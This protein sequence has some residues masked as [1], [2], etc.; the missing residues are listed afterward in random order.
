MPSKEK[1]N[2]KA[3]EANE[4]LSRL[5]SIGQIATGIAHEVK[6]PLTAV[7]G[8]LQLLQNETEHKYLQIAMS[9]LD[10]ALDTLNNLLQVSRPD[11]HN[12]P[13]V[14]INLCSELESIIYLFQEHMYRVEFVKKFKDTQQMIRGRK[15]LLKKAF[16]NLI[17]NAL[18]AIPGEGKITIEHY[19][20]RPHLCIKLSDT[21][22]GIPEE[23]LKLLGTP[24]F[25]TKENGTGMGLTQVY[26]TLYDHGATVE[27]SSSVNVGTTF[28]I[29]F[30]LIKTKEV[31]VKQMANLTYTAGQSLKDFILANRME[32]DKLLNASTDAIFSDIERSEL[33]DTSHLNDVAYQLIGYIDDG[34]EH[35]LILLAHKIGMAWAKSDI[36][37]ILKLEWFRSFREIYWDLL[38]HY[39]KHVQLDFEQLFSLE[40]S[41]NYLMDTFL[42]HYFNKYNE[43]KN[44]L[45]RSQREVID[46]LTVPVIPLSDDI[47]ILPLIG[48]LDTY[49]AK[50]IQERTL[51]RINQGRISHIILDLSGV[52]YMDTG[53]V[54]H[55]FKMVDGFTLL[56]CQTTVTGIRPEI[57]N[58]VVE[59]GIEITNRVKTFGSLQQALEKE[60]N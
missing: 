33:V 17:K 7:K 3:S 54:Q 51:E 18:E 30:P 34:A 50:K 25:S 24:F 52:A 49:R 27:V 31:T 11:I 2:Q 8:F 6:N 43:Y 15:N 42:T 41:T 35:E 21:G 45:L 10:N 53:V 9:Q 1:V 38:Y 14:P 37:A 4:S 19:V 55:L 26:T 59:M 47:A 56:G 39:Y 44:E 58:T 16:F 57:A 12:E 28:V 13:F 23:K 40:K 48:T 22:V 36:P 46:E 20:D 60:I 5:A 29:K 32:I